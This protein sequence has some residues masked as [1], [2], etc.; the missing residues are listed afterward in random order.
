VIAPA[1]IARGHHT[2]VVAVGAPGARDEV[3]A[4]WRGLG[5]DEADL[6]LCA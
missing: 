6:L 4:R 1:Q 5:G 2:I 3:R